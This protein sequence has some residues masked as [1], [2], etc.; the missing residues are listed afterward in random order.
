MNPELNTASTAIDYT[1]SYAV[2]PEGGTA[3]TGAETI[4]ESG[5]LETTA[6]SDA[7]YAQSTNEIERFNFAQELFQLES[8]PSRVS[9]KDR[10]LE[11][12]FK[13]MAESDSSGDLPDAFDKSR[14]KRD[15]H[16]AFTA[17]IDRHIGPKAR[18]FGSD[19]AHDLSGFDAELESPLDIE[20]RLK[21]LDIMFKDHVDNASDEGSDTLDDDFSMD[22]GEIS[23]T[24]D[25]D[26]ADLSALDSESASSSSETGIA[27]ASDEV[28]STSG[29]LSETSADDEDFD[30]IKSSSSGDAT[31]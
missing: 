17:V 15:G 29:E 23:E 18:K 22:E 12:V 28:D 5:T 20:K 8:K 4:E 24:G 31:A 11:S 19:H 6:D 25:I 27:Y 21:Y 13:H 16:P 14:G 1:E 10:E 2:T 9:L 30:E 26:S 3:T 7:S